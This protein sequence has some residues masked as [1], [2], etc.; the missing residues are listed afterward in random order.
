[1]VASKAMEECNHWL[2]VEWLPEYAPEL[3]D[4]EA[5][6]KNLKATG[7]AHRTF[8]DAEHL[9]KAIYRTV[10]KRNAEREINPWDKKESLLSSLSP[11]VARPSCN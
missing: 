1:M 9:E 5:A 6:W 8:H 7:L 4:I 11:G 2:T 3:N 10:T